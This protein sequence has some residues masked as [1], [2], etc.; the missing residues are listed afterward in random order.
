MLLSADLLVL[1][2]LPPHTSVIK[3]ALGRS[4]HLLPSEWG[5][6]IPLEWE[7]I[8][9]TSPRLPPADPA[10]AQRDPLVTQG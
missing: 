5:E 2:G 7:E 3:V 1:T 8:A 6:K 10:L 9:N 4:F